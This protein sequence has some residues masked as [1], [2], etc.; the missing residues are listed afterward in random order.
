MPCPELVRALVPE[1]VV[2][3]SGF[4]T[5]ALSALVHLVD[6]WHVAD[7]GNAAHVAH[8]T[9]ALL[10]SLRTPTSRALAFYILVHRLGVYGARR[11]LVQMDGF[12]PRASTAARYWQE[13][14]ERATL[15][16][17]KVLGVWLCCGR[18]CVR[19]DG[20]NVHLG[21][22]NCNELGAFEGRA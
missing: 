15:D 5:H 2:L 7:D 18:S 19:V 13:A 22:D 20:P 14:F 12:E 8:A 17:P 1:L 11:L 6:A 9:S 4:T 16:A 3:L 21:A 10:C